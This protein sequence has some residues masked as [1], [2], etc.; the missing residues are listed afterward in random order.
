MPMAMGCMLR[1]SV[2]GPKDLQLLA[3]ILQFLLHQFCCGWFISWSLEEEKVLVLD[4]DCLQGI[5]LVRWI[6]VKEPSWISLKARD[7]GIR[8]HLYPLL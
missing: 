8:V 3:S 4:A 2:E 1:A 5:V 7:S 6:L